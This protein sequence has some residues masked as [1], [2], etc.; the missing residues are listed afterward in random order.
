MKER[1]SGSSPFALRGVRGRHGHPA[2]ADPGKPHF[3]LPERER[4]LFIGCRASG[5]LH[6]LKGESLS[7]N[8]FDF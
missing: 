2:A 1:I 3:R 7:V 6:K 4:E 5:R 8:S